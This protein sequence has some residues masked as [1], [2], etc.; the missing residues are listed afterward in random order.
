MCVGIT[1]DYIRACKRID[2]FPHEA[3]QSSS[4]VFFTSISATAMSA[5]CFRFAKRR[6]PLFRIRVAASLELDP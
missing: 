2:S 3:V 4:A 5:L 1:N 6:R